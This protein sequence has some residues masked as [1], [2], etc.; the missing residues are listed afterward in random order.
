MLTFDGDGGVGQSETQ[1]RTTVVD[2]RPPLRLGCN[3][4][5]DSPSFLAPQDGNLILAGLPS[6]QLRIEEVILD[7]TVQAHSAF[8]NATSHFENLF[9]PQRV[10]ILTKDVGQTQ[11]SRERSQQFMRQ[12]RA[13]VHPQLL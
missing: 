4:F 11:D 12:S 2:F 7:Q 9:P 13:D 5:L 10:E 1:I 8:V 3:E 6:D